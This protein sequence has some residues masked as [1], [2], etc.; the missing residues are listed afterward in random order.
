MNGSVESFSRP[1]VVLAASGLLLTAC[2]RAEPDRPRVEVP[3]PVVAPAAPLPV[4]VITTLDRRALLD[5][6]RL[7]AS[8]HAAGARSEGPD[9]LVGKR[10][11]VSLAF[12][13]EGPQPV[14]E[15][16][17]EGLARWSWAPER[18]AIR[19]SMTPGDWTRSALVDGTG[20]EAV[21]GFWIARPWLEGPGCPAPITDPLTSEQDPASPQTAGLAAVFETGGSRLERRDGRAYAVSVRP[22]GAAEAVTPPP[23]GYRL[24]L[25]GRIGAFPDGRAIRCRSAGPDQ[26]PVCIA[27][28]RLD[29]VAFEEA[30]GSSLAEWRVGG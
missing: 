2:G 14:V 24:R 30:E 13:C 25:Q 28:V 20:W 10:F 26:R 18:R 23:D 7:A 11:S 9:A 12:G 29:R 15:G 4:P 1:L 19:L 16:Q 21:E 8:N 3:P 5:A 27:A 22:D 17:A 6:L